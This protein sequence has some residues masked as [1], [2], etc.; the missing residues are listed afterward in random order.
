MNPSRGR[1][2]LRP[3]ADAPVVIA[4]FSDFECLFC[5][6]LTPIL[7]QIL[8][9][10]PDKI[11]IV[12]K[13]FPLNNHK[14]AAMAAQAALAAGR[15]NKFWEY[16]DRLFEYADQLNNS[17]IIEIAEEI[18]LD[19]KRFKKDMVQPEITA[20]INQD[21]RDGRRAGI[22]GVPTVF[23]NGRRLKKHSIESF[24]EMIEEELS[25]ADNTKQQRQRKPSP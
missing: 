21:V 6:R 12:F 7:D 8:E 19:V 23:V 2:P 10:Y 1:P 18:D 20:M 5:K 3:R 11:K 9:L 16:H 13:N 24:A 15:Q 4:E 22:R 17:K 25:K 14:Q